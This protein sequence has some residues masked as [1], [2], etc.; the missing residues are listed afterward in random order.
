MQTKYITKQNPKSNKTYV[1][2]NK[3]MLKSAKKN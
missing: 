3:Q 1:R 2:Q